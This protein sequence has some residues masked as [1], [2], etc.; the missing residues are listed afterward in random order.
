MIGLFIFAGLLI[1]VLGILFRRF[2]WGP[3]MILIIGI[4]LVIGVG[5]Y[6][7]ILPPKIAVQGERL[8]IKGI[9]GIQLDYQDIMGVTLSN[10]I[11]PVVIKTNGFNFGN[12]LRGSFRLKG[13]GTAKLFVNRDIAP[14][15][16]IATRRSYIIVNYKEKAKTV[17]TFNRV[18]KA[19][20]KHRKN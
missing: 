19:W 15:I 3:R 13:I 11:P 5:I 8:V 20:K 2:K 18:R 7:C 17:K 12:I 9:Y 6:L 1:I 10:T 16:C 14:F 4:F